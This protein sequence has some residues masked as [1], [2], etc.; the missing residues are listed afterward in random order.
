MA[1]DIPLGT[2]LTAYPDCVQH[3]TDNLA[4]GGR[5]LRKDEKVPARR[6]LARE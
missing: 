4:M 6:E 2:L 1:S 3:S 5:Q